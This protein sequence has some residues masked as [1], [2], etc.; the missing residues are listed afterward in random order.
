MILNKLNKLKTN[1]N[2]HFQSR[3]LDLYVTHRTH[4]RTWNKSKSNQVSCIFINFTLCCDW[5]LVQ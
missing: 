4:V 1:R 2:F 3:Q 5:S